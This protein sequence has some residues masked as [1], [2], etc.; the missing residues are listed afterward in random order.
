MHELLLMFLKTV[1]AN[2][3]DFFSTIV[4]VCLFCHYLTWFENVS[5]CSFGRFDIQFVFTV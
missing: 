2:L 4:T 3:L 1:G 5:Y